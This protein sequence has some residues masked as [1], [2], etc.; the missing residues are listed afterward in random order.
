[1]PVGS[2][3]SLLGD[4][5]LRVERFVLDVREAIVPDEGRLRPLFVAVF[6]LIALI[7][8]VVTRG[9]G[10]HRGQLPE[11]CPPDSGPRRPTS[12]W[13]YLFPRALYL[14]PSA[15]FDYKMY[16]ANGVLRGLVS[17]TTLI[18]STRA[19]AT[20]TH[21]VL[22]G[23]LGARPPAA[24]GPPFWFCLLFTVALLAASDLG[25][26]LA[27]VLEHKVPHLWA[28]HKVHH[29]AE[30]LT[31]VTVA[32]VHPVDKVL[33][34]AFIA[35][36]AG[37]TTGVFEYGS[38]HEMTLVL[39]LGESAVR[40]FFNILFN[41]RHSHIWMPYPRL[42]SHVFT[43]PAMHIVH[44]SAADRHRDTNFAAYFGLWD[45]ALGTLYIPG[46]SR[47]DREFTLGLSDGDSARY[48]SLYQGF[49][50]PF[51]D[52][53]R[54]LRSPPASRRPSPTGRSAAP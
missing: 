25:F 7:S 5:R 16:L 26:F 39:I 42:L 45:W 30:V 36:L 19:V 49:L 2:L 48:R 27:H 54:H 11:S 6:V 10:Q 34:G 15:M 23:L 33:E 18:L 28:F 46:D 4:H 21:R 35:V 40:F 53:A 14:H 20:A 51:V 38:R 41:L 50:G 37:I 29:S 24:A 13:G 22:T 3:D 12:A 52:L 8:Y 17:L 32:R 9:R 31:P 1:M 47:E 43:S 44:H